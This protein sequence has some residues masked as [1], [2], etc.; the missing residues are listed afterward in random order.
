[1]TAPDYWRFAQMLLRGGELNGT[2]VLKPESV[3]EMTRN[4]IGAT[5]FLT[6]KFHGLFV[7]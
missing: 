5:A 2:R 6:S 1:M 3:R 4:Q 7:T